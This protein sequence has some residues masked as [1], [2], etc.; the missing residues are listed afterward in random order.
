MTAANRISLIAPS[1]RPSLGNCR[2]NS[3]KLE[4]SHPCR[5]GAHNPLH[6]PCISSRI[7]GRRA[8]GGANSKACVAI[9]AP[10]FECKAAVIP[11]THDASRFFKFESSPPPPVPSLIPPFMPPSERALCRYV[12]LI[13]I[14]AVFPSIEPR[15]AP[16]WYRIFRSSSDPLQQR[17]VLRRFR[18]FGQSDPELTA[19][20]R[21][22]WQA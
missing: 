9:V 3:C 17:A 2:R 20:G 11:N 5:R 21:A 1:T 6:I 12:L 16:L 15:A 10:F 13:A 19:P 4:H 14:T 22:R 18:V 8:G 7:R